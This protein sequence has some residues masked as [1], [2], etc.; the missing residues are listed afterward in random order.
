MPYAAV[1]GTGL[2]CESAGDGPPVVFVHG[3]FPSVATRLEDF[4][5]WEWTWERDFAAR[6]HFVWYDR[7]GFWRS[8]SP[9][10]GYSLENQAKD[11]ADVLDYLR[12]DSAHVIGS[13]AGGPIAAIFAARWPHRTR[14]LILT[15]TGLELFPEEGDPVS[16]LIRQQIALLAKSGAQVAFDRRP[17]GV[18][19]SFEILWRPEEEEVRGRLDEYLQRENVRTRQAQHLPP[20]DRAHY[21]AVELHGL[22]AYMERDIRADA[23]QITAPVLVLHGSDDREVPLGLGREIVQTIPGARLHVVQGGGHSLVHR[24][25]EGRQLAIDFISEHEDAC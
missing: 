1:N 24:T 3:G 12:L 5:T 13:S 10:D 11:L 25:R 19:T 16:A 22:K 4:D 9:V 7:R 20:S 6:F 21:Y 23:R 18:E 17:A 2:Y 8:A 15:G 14:S